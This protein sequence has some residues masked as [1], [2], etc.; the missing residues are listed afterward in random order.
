MPGR[1]VG[2]AKLTLAGDLGE[3]T[4][5]HILLMRHGFKMFGANAERITAEM[6]DFEAGSDGA[7]DALQGETMRA[8]LVP[9]MEE[10]PVAAS[11]C[12]GRP[13][14]AGAGPAHLPI[15]SLLNLAHKTRIADHRGGVKILLLIF[16]LTDP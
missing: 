2:F 9:F 4:P 12:A 6:V 5:P 7:A 1:A 11:V 13:C 3:A 14:P 10:H 16:C 8:N 15:E